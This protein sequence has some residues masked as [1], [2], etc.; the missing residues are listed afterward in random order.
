MRKNLEQSLIVQNLMIE[1]VSAT[2]IDI[3]FII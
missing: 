1:V 2:D 3:L